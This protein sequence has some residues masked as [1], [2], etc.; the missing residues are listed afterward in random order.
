M[1]IKVLHHEKGGYGSK[2]LSTEFPNKAFELKATVF[3]VL[4]TCA[5]SVSVLTDKTITT[6]EKQ[7][8]EI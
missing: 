2:K 6:Q 5:F 1:L 7:F 3:I 4:E 8:T